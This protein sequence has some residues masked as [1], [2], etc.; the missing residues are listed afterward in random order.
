MCWIFPRILGWALRDDL[1]WAAV[2]CAA[3][4]RFE[5]AEKL[6]VAPGSIEESTRNPQISDGAFVLLPWQETPCTWCKDPGREES[7]VPCQWVPW[8][9]KWNLASTPDQLLILS[10][11]FWWLWRFL[12]FLGGFP[13][14]N[15]FIDG[16]PGSFGSSQV[17]KT[18][19]GWSAWHS[20]MAWWS[21][22]F[23][24]GWGR[25]VV[26][27]SLIHPQRIHEMTDLVW[28]IHDAV[29]ELSHSAVPLAHDSS[30]HQPVFA[31]RRKMQAWQLQKS[32][33]SPFRV[34]ILHGTQTWVSWVQVKISQ[35]LSMMEWF[36][37]HLRFCMF[38]YLLLISWFHWRGQWFLVPL[39]DHR[40][41]HVGHRHRNM[42]LRR[43]DLRPLQ[44]LLRAELANLHAGDLAK[45][46]RS[47]W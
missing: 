25:W 44:Q 42:G 11:S 40:L 14:L 21:R 5:R 46:D 28:T 2:Q 36:P 12:D 18:C 16:P 39:S 47:Y 22:R 3:W 27:R 33:A 13:K 17:A 31:S 26:H 23:D 43:D 35:Q 32:L 24:S 29:T 45:T 7:R 8:R 1:V 6:R 4:S 10:W 37:I 30:S 38:L 34:Y 41:G 20:E 9:K 15:L 19:Y